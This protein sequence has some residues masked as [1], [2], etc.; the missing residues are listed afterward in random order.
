MIERESTNGD[1]G[2]H[3]APSET[4]PEQTEAAPENSPFEPFGTEKIEKGQDPPGEERA[5]DNA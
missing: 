4:P 1:G 5:T 3:P 2:Q